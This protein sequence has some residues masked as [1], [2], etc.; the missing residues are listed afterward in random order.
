M[1]EPVVYFFMRVGESSTYGKA[2]RGYSTSSSALSGP[3]WQQCYQRGG[4]KARKNLAVH[5]M[6][7]PLQH[8]LWQYLSLH[9]KQQDHQ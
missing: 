3:H 7:W 2:Q 5:S 9:P 6:A 4:Q 1:V 8:P